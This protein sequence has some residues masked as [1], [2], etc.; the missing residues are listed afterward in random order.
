MI[1][2]PVGSVTIAASARTPSATSAR[3]PRLEYSS[4]TTA[5][6]M[7]S[8]SIAPPLAAEARAAAAHIAA[9]PAFMSDEPR[10]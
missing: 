4:S 9:T 5:V 3:V 2:R 1:L 6:T 8:P 10:P 7:I